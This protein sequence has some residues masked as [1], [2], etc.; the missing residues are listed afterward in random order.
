MVVGWGGFGSGSDGR[1]SPVSR[2]RLLPRF[3]LP[4]SHQRFSLPLLGALLL[5]SLSRS[6]PFKIHPSSSHALFLPS[7]GAVV[8]SRA[9]SGALDDPL[10]MQEPRDLLQLHGNNLGTGE[11]P[12]L[13]F[14]GFLASRPRCDGIADCN[15][16]CG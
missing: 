8:G 6:L 1:A 10:M 13:A 11:P 4:V 14:L 12:F 16:H 2:Q 15:R 7:F 5:D 9:R 3:P